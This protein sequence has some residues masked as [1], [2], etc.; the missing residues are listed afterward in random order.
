MN[1]DAGPGAAAAGAAAGDAAERRSD[2]DA[3][4]RRRTEEALR[5]SEER[6][7]RFVA[8]SSEGIWRIELDAPAPVSLPPDT[9]IA[10]F[11]RH[12]YLAECNDA[13]ARMYGYGAAGELVGARL[14]AL[15]PLSDPDNAA[16]LR[17]KQERMG[18]RYDPDE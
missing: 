7:R 18:H 13:M 15:L 5:L 4:S 8:Q 12:A 1:A 14:G 6:Y 10:H 3:R 16:Y 2:L 11:Y 17:T 9:Q